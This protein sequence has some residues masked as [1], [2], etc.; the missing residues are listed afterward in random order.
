MGGWESKARPAAQPQAVEPAEHAE[1]A[2]I[3][4][5]A[6][7]V[8]RQD[9]QIRFPPDLLVASHPL[10]DAHRMIRN[11]FHRISSTVG[12]NEDGLTETVKRQL[13]D[14]IALE[15]LITARSSELD[16]RL[17]RML[18]LF[19]TLETEVRLATEMLA[20]EAEKAD[21]LAAE[22]DPG[23]GSFAEFGQR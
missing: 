5:V 13:E 10:P 1:Y 7:L 15:S 3:P 14:Y 6:P 8:L 9:A 2:G 12:R 18:G 17:A 4:R 22:V 11:Y 23:L 19:R 21:R 20:L 16:G